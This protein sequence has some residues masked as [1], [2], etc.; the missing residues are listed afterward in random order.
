MSGGG[1]GHG[2]ALE[3]ALQRC[4]AI[5]F[6]PMLAPLQLLCGPPE[7]VFLRPLCPRTGS[8][9][10]LNFPRVRA[11]H[12]GVWIRAR[13]ASSRG[14]RS[15]ATR[16][17]RRP[18]CACTAARH[19]ST[20]RRMRDRCAP[21]A[22]RTRPVRTQA[23]RSRTTWLACT[24]ARKQRANPRS[25]TEARRQEDQGRAVIAGHRRRDR[26]L[27]RSFARRAGVHSLRR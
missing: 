15:T 13:P 23:C 26:P 17:G 22:P 12:R 9:L 20:R 16:I 7:I 21:F 27:R 3:R 25:C 14:S 2:V 10:V 11:S 6:L 18:L 4:T 19:S 24:R 1:T 8:P 5:S